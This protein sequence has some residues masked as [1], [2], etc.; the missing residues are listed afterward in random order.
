LSEGEI[1]YFNR[2]VINKI[3]LQSTAE[4]EIYKIEFLVFHLFTNEQYFQ[5]YDFLIDYKT[6]LLAEKYFETNIFLQFQIDL[7][8]RKFAQL[9]KESE[10]LKLIRVQYGQL[11]N[12]LNC[13][14]INPLLLFN[15]KVLNETVE[16]SKRLSLDRKKTFWQNV[17]VELIQNQDQLSNVNDVLKKFDNDIESIGVIERNSNHHFQFDGISRNNFFLLLNYLL[18]NNFETKWLINRFD[19]LPNFALSRD[20]ILDDLEYFSDFGMVSN[21]NKST[22]LKLFLESLDR[23]SFSD[24]YRNKS[25]CLKFVSRL[26]EINSD[27]YLQKIS[28]EEITI[29]SSLTQNNEQKKYSYSRKYSI[30]SLPFGMNTENW[31]N[32][33][34]DEID[35][36]D[37][38]RILIKELGSDAVFLNEDLKFLFLNCLNEV[39]SIT[40]GELADYTIQDEYQDQMVLLFIIIYTNNGID[41]FLDTLEFF[42]SNFE[43]SLWN[44]YLGEVGPLNIKET[45]LDS[46]LIFIIRYNNSEQNIDTLL[47]SNLLNKYEILLCFCDILNEDALKATNL[48]KFNLDELT[49]FFHDEPEYLF[50]I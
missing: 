14:K 29:S 8:I 2:L 12:S 19:W 39:C 17:L 15:V 50:H 3:F 30:Y 38:I 40:E 20:G 33:I 9:D 37:S 32:I 26:S 1:K 42:S 46:V 6:F 10:V 45:I 25:W 21:N 27:N 11:E 44:E 16:A 31:E 49:D 43:I 28:F 36:Y 7:C 22:V 4:F 13:I 35:E 18:E 5:A 41:K 24:L 23:K 48:P 34:N 47:K